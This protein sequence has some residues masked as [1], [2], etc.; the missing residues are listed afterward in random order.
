MAK[1]YY[2]GMNEYRLEKITSTQGHYH[3]AKSL[4]NAMRDAKTRANKSGIPW[5]VQIWKP[6]RGSQIYIILPTGMENKES[7]W[8]G[9]VSK[10]NLIDYYG[11]K[12]YDISHIKSKK[13]V[14]SRKSLY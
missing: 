1:T 11:A 5:T 4:K 7:A 3:L 14:I 8:N 13:F 12:D 6:E 9:L 2:N 10:N